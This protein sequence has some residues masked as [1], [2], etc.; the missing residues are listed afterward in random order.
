MKMPWQVAN[1]VEILDLADDQAEGVEEGSSSDLDALQ[2]RGAVIKISKG[3][4]M[5]FPR[6]GLVGPDELKP[7]DLVGVNDHTFQIVAKLPPHFDERVKTM[8]LVERPTETYSEIGGCETQIKELKEAIVLPMTKKELFIKIGIHPPKGVLMYGPPGTGKT[9][10]ARAVASQTKATFLRLSGT[11]LNQ[12]GLGD[13]AKLVQN[14]FG[15]AKQKAP[16]IIF[17]DEL[18]AIGTKRFDGSDTG[19]R[20]IQLELLNQLDGFQPN[21]DIKVIAA[22]NRVDL[23]DPALLRSGRFDRKME[24]TKPNE[25]SRE[26]I[27]RIH[28][29]WMNVDNNVNFVEL[30]RC[31]E[32]FN[33]AQC[34]AVCVEAGMVALRRD[35]TKIRHEDFMDGILEVQGL[36]KNNLV[37]YG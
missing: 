24:F 1:V 5:F 36:K 13:G 14:A 8:E 26:Q 21:D 20:G 37:Y 6:I 10:R 2:K 35:S 30:S 29:R 25:N 4:V 28:S 22:T 19:Y 31:I 12:V 9:L 16:A 15:L 32:D 11:L 34:R 18:D 3:L 27:L 17:I 23:L 33:G 7:G